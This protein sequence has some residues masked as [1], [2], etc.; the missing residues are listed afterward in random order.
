MKKAL[1]SIILL[2]TFSTQL[3]AQTDDDAY[4]QKLEQMFKLAGSEEAY[5]AVIKQMTTMY[6]QQ[7]PK[8][9]PD[10]WDEFEKEFSSASMNDLTTMLTP[11]YKKHLSSED[12]DG[13]IAFYQT[14][15]GR[16]YA[17]KTP[18]IMQESMQVGQEWGIKLGKELDKKMKA[19]GY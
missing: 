7:Y 13:I 16:K 10:F 3:F 4:I 12:L 18:L 14:P 17:M 1:F 8:A 19:K 5:K 2:F 9:E 11:V 15:V 6:K